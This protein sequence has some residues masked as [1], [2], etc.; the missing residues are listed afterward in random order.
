MRDRYHY[1]MFVLVM[2]DDYLRLIVTRFFRK[3]NISPQIHLRVFV[4]ARKNQ[5]TMMPF[6]LYLYKHIHFVT[7]KQENRKMQTL[8]G[9][10]NVNGKLYAYTTEQF[11]KN[12]LW[13]Y[14]NENDDM[15]VEM[16]LADLWEEPQFT[17]NAFWL[18]CSYLLIKE[19]H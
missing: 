1:W 17:S 8:C 4:W 7:E 11:L 12:Y 3:L 6:T 5:E 2:V 15:F 13:V 18:C 16:L 9:V 14:I 19:K 10:C